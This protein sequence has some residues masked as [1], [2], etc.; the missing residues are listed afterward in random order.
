MHSKYAFD[1]IICGVSLAHQQ[2]FTMDEFTVVVAELEYREE[3]ESEDDK[4]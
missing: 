3:S 4:M 1:F 2:Q